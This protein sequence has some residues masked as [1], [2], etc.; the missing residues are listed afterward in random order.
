MHRVVYKVALGSNRI[1]AVKKVTYAGLKGGSQSVVREIQTVENIQHRNLISLEDYWFE[2]EHGLLLY[3]YEPN[4]SLYDVLHEMNGD[5]SV[6][7]ALKVR[8]NIS[9]I[10]FL[11]CC[12][13][14]NFFPFS[15]LRCC[16][17]TNFFPFR[18]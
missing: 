17:W 2:K 16:S 18:L 7:L 13:W 10:S 1:F 15:F 8:H 5:S 3:K 9:W 14:I 12:S 6:A 4:G 11:R